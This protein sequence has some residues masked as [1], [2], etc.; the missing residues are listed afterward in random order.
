[1]KGQAGSLE[2]F[3]DFYWTLPVH[4]MALWQPFHATGVKGFSCLASLGR[5]NGKV[6]VG[7]YRSTK[8][9]RHAA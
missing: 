2:R 9:L 3:Q 7:F 8:A 4:L 5:W 6:L 1:M